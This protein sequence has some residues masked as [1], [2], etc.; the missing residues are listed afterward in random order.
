MA[1]DAA[2]LAWLAFEQV[3]D[4]GPQLT[5]RLWPGG[6]EQVLAKAGAHVHKVAWKG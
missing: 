5:L 2:P 3:S 4:A 6:K 1:T